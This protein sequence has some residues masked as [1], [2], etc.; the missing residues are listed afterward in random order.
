MMAV[1]RRPRR[2]AEGEAETPVNGT[3][4]LPMMPSAAA[5]NGSLPHPPAAPSAELAVPAR[6]AQIEAHAAEGPGPQLAADPGLYAVLGLAPD[7]PDAVI[8]TTYRRQAARLLGSGSNDNA[9]LRQ[10]NVAY[11]VLGNPVRRA[12][13]DRMRLTQSTSGPPTPIRSGAKVAAQVTRRRRPRHAVQPRYAGLGDVLVV[14]VVVIAASLAGA[15][16]ILPRLSFNLTALNALQNVL[17]LSNSSRRVI[18]TTVTPAPATPVPTATPRP[19]TAERFVGSNVS[20]SDPT[21][22]QNARESVV[23]QLRRDRQPAPGFDVWAIVKYRTTEE[24]WPATGSVKTDGSGAATISFNVGAATPN[25]PVQVQVFAQVDDQQL[26][27]ST[28]FTPH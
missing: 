17:P 15:F 11:E 27:W 20:V 4:E 26:S 1:P 8:Q 6:G 24:R 19:G 5:G 9:A 2:P 18:D 13:Y 7:V 10:L 28:T 16:I 25:Y 22:A 23:I 21:P 12:E 14:L 3:L